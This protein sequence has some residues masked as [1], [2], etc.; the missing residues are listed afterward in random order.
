MAQVPLVRS[1]QLTQSVSTIISGLGVATPASVTAAQAAAAADATTKANAAIASSAQR[2]NNLSDLANAATA[3]ANLGLVIGTDVQPLD[4]DL[5]AIAATTTAAFGRAFLALADATAGRTLLNLGTAA[6]TA[7]T[8]YEVAGT[9]ATAQAAAIAASQPLDA[10][11][12]ALAST[13]S[14]ADRVP[15]YTGASTAT[16][17]TVTTA[18]RTVLDDTTTAAMLITLGAAPTVELINTVGTSGASQTIPA[19]S[20]ATLNRITLTANC[21]FTFP[22][23]TAG[24][25]FTLELIQDGTGSR[26]VTLP[27]SVRWAS[28]T[29]PTLTITAAKRDVLVFVCTDGSTWF[30]FTSGQNFA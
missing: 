23:A 1:D 29:A 14:A 18:A 10:E 24:T 20:T 6:T 17:M 9:A 11:L 8:A 13:T 15:Y 22:T 3:R 7:A 21:T 27:A 28:G 16:T 30:G 26:T 19:T 4:A 12:T 5:T 25:S 2:A